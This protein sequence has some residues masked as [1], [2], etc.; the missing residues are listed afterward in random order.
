MP[1]TAITW[2]NKVL[3]TRGTRVYQVFDD[4]LEGKTVQPMLC[5]C[6]LS[7]PTEKELP[8]Q[9]NKCLLSFVNWEAE[10]NLEDERHI[11]DYFRDIYVVTFE[12]GFDMNGSP[13]QKLY[14]LSYSTLTKH[15]IKR[16][17]C[18]SMFRRM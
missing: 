18:S 1:K 16:K 10:E 6:L 7:F 15:M 8:F 14:M 4:K 12:I 11:N 3:G 17:T 5:A 2:F 13:Y 9:V